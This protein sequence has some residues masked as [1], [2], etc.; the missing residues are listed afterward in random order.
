[1]EKTAW[2]SSTGTGG[3]KA[4]SGSS[5]SSSSSSS[6]GRTVSGKATTIGR[7]YQGSNSP[8]TADSSRGS[9]ASSP[10]S[11]SGNRGGKA[12]TGPAGKELEQQTLEGTLSKYTNLI[13]GWQS[14]YF[15]LE[16]DSGLLQYFV[17]E[18]SKNQ[19]PRGFLSLMGAKI[20]ISEEEP[21]MFTIYSTNG[22]F[23]KLRAAD[24]KERKH[25]VSHLQACIKYHTD[26]NAK[27][28]SSGRA[29]SLSL[30]PH[31]GLNATPS[32]SQRQLSHSGPSIITITHHK[33]PAA[34]RKSKIQHPGQLHEVKEMM[35]H[36]EGQ[37]KTLVH[38][39]ESLPSSGPL[40]SLDQDLLLLKAT[41][42]ATLS[43]LGECLNILQ[44][45]IHQVTESSKTL[46]S[47][48]TPVWHG[49][50]SISSEQ[51]KN[52]GLSSLLSTG[53]N[54]SWPAGVHATQGTHE[55]EE[56]AEVCPIKNKSF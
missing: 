27:A 18:Q 10:S 40:S 19:K 51:L 9:M 47:D 36:A 16:Y 3:S 39:I 30:L 43:C 33:S 7:Q 46:P 12:G 50:K 11:G 52:Q 55:S 44:Q 17:N 49:R 4:N 53:A 29:K 34:A 14:R 38:S 35:S 41:S 45:S 26:S 22:E 32:S 5:S 20:L 24:A 13:Q 54:F 1:M 23:Y 6:L 8:A 2:S 42:A 21:N 15:L 56:D 48:A 37:Q 28:S 25:W 31:G